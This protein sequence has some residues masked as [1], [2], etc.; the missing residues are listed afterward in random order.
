MPS[1]KLRSIVSKT[2]IEGLYII[3]RPTFRDNRGFFRE[4]ARVSDLKKVGIN[5]KPLQWNHSFSEPR[6]IRALHA[7]NWNKLIY[8]LTGK[9]FAAIVDIR[10]NEKTFG[11]VETFTFDEKSPKALFITKGL[12]N[13]ICVM[14]R[15]PVHYMYLVDKYY[16]GS[17]VRAIAWDDSD[18]SIN[19]PVKNPIISERDQKNP[20]IRE[21]FPSKFK[22]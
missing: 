15:K 10:P 18:L 22:K 20:T 3:E 6:V 9:M 17:D 2:S 14:G 8:P 16:D 1:K 11:K 13:S 4:I 19:W 5:F 7:E 12:A 21:L